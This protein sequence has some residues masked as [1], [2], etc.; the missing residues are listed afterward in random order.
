MVSFVI[1]P[2]TQKKIKSGVPR[3]DG[4]NGIEA[5]WLAMI[6]LELRISD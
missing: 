6:G 3:K 2:P 1:P 5:S 4:P